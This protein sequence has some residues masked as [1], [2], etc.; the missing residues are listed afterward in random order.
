MLLA[1]K[2]EKKAAVKAVEEANVRVI[3]KMIT[4]FSKEEILEDFSFA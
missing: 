3:R 2:Y 1:E 4:R